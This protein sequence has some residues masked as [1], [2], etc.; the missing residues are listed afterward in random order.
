[1]LEDDFAVHEKINGQLLDL[2]LSNG[3]YR[4]GF[5]VFTTHYVSPLAD[6][7]KY[8]AIWLRYMVKSVA[9]KRKANSIIAKNKDFT[10]TCSPLEITDEIIALHHL[11][12][13]SL[14]FE[15][16]KH[17]PDFLMEAKNHT[18]ESHI[19]AVRDKEKLVACGI[20]DKGSDSIAGIINF[21]DPAY[22]PY[23]PGKFLILQNY[24]YCLQN[25]ITWYYPGYYMLGHPLFDYKLF[26]DKAATKVYIPEIQNWLGLGDFQKLLTNTKS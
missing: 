23:S 5:F 9:L 22:K 24:I 21:Y 19:I 17:L 15:I 1:M 11:Y 7:V 12:A 10:V 26:L 6:N 20:F 16:T 2:Y 8:R 18:F 4:Q 14:S 25:N 3:W 13:N